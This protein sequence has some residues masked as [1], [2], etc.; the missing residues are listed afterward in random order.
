MDYILEA[1]PFTNCDEEP[2][3]HTI[4]ED[5]IKN[6]EVPE[7]KAFTNENDKKKQRRKR[8]VRYQTNLLKDIRKITYHKKTIFVYICMYILYVLFFIKLIHNIFHIIIKFY[9][10]RLNT[11]AGS[12]GSIRM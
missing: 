8:K 10:Y 4:I 9:K 12:T 2:R 11:V 6:G 3:L 1:V 7:Y 5:L